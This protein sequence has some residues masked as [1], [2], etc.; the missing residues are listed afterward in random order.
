MNILRSTYE[1]EKRI[2]I[3]TILLILLMLLFYVN[4]C[5]NRLPYYSGPTIIFTVLISIIIYCA[6]GFEEIQFNKITFYHLLIAGFS[7]VMLE[8]IIQQLS[9]MLS[10]STQL[11]HNNLFYHFG[12]ASLLITII[13]TSIDEICIRGI[14]QPRLQL[15]F[16]YLLGAIFTGIFW[17]SKKIIFTIIYRNPLDDILLSYIYI[18]LLSIT[19]S[20]ILAYYYG[21]SKNLLIPILFSMP[22]NNLYLIQH[23]N[24]IINE[25]S[26]PIHILRLGLWILFAELTIWL[27]LNSKN[28]KTQKGK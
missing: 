21:N 10:I 4:H 19:F 22:I 3:I 17:G 1:I 15:K 7:P 27:W 28:L 14:I 23:S 18:I 12:D 20:I 11:A 16:G 13:Y 2:G 9:I 5:F 25:A 8:F 6:T 26:F 24:L